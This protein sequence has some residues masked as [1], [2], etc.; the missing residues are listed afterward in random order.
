MNAFFLLM[1]RYIQLL[2]ALN[3]NIYQRRNGRERE[4][5]N[6][7]NPKRQEMKKQMHVQ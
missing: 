2:D 1:R 4:A 7:Y 5:E 6:Q 3:V